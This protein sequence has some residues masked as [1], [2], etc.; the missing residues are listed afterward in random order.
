MAVIFDLPA[1]VTSE[2]VHISPAVLLNPEN[3]GVA[4]EICYLVQTL[5]Y[6][7]ISYVL[8]VLAAIFDLLV[9]RVA[10]SVHTISAVLLDPEIVGVAF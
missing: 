9:T 5:R 10:E 8:P 1:T 4:F 6:C 2:R 3:L 7:V